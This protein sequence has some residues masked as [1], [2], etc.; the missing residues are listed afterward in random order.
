[1]ILEKTEGV[2]FFIE[3]FVK[4]LIDLEIIDKDN[5]HY[6]LTRDVDISIP[7]TIQD[8]VMARVDSLPEDAK[9]ILQIGSVI[10]REFSY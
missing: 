2:P 8:V 9:R 7:S 10:G 4:S 5:N 1:L 6:Y 3:E